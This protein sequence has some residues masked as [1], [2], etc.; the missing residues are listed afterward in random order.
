MIEMEN[1]G[2][3]YR[4]PL[5]G[6]LGGRVRA[7]DGVTLSVAAGSS[8]GLVGPN[9]A[10]KSTLIRLLLGYLRPSAGSLLVGGLAPRAYAERHGIGYVPERPTIPTGWSVRGAL[11]AFAALGDVPGTPHRVRTFEQL[12]GL[13]ELAHRRVATLSKGNLQR[14]TLAQALLGDRRVLILDEPTDGVDPEWI[15][16]IRDVLTDWRNAA[17]QRVLIFAS[18][19][20]HEVER[21]ADRVAVLVGGKVR[22]VLDLRAPSPALP[23]YR[24]EVVGSADRVAAQMTAAFP[25]ALQVDEL[26]DDHAFS[27]WTVEASDLA[28]LNERLSR[29]LQAGVHLRSVAPQQRSLEQQFRNSLRD[30]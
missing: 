24:I 18:H 12:F 15:A 30:G 23:P 4:G 26:A 5:R 27:A 22:E 28:E 9:G 21:I 14:L 11:E 7:L 20:L 8:L 2:K 6:A 10:G 1:V 25:T 17:P 29:L 3:E 13:E 19:N 16:R